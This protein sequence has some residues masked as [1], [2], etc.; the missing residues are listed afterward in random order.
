MMKKFKIM[1]LVIAITMTMALLVGCGG[2]ATN[3]VME[4]QILIRKGNKLQLIHLKVM[5]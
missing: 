3:K 5:V 2:K 4:Q 1:S